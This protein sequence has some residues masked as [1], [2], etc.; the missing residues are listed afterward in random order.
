MRSTM[1]FWRHAGGHAY[2]VTDDDPSSGGFGC[3][4][5]SV[6]RAGRCIANTGPR[7]VVTT[8]VELAMEDEKRYQIDIGTRDL[9]L[10][11]VSRTATVRCPLVYYLQHPQSN[12]PI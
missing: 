3:D 8:Y 4:V 2:A 1:Q 6:E 9:E 5:V 7:V 12:S 10:S 11:E